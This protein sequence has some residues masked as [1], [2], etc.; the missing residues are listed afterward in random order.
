MNFTNIKNI[1]FTQKTYGGAPVITKGWH[2]IALTEIG[3]EKTT[4]NG[5]ARGAVF[6]FKVVDG[7]CAGMTFKRWFCTQALQSNKNWTQAQ[8]ETMMARIAQVAGKNE[9]HAVEELFGVPFYTCITNRNREY[10]TINEE[11]G[12]K[13]TK[14]TVDVDFAQGMT[15]AELVLSPTEYDKKFNEPLPF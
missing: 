3:E 13:E 9:L 4:A 14:T 8:Y 1:D 10:S 7:D 5:D 6:T 11:T 12:Q 2:K 15:L